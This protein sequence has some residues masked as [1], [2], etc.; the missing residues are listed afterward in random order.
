VLE[1][2]KKY[3]D[4]KQYDAA[5]TNVNYITRVLGARK[6]IGTVVIEGTDACDDEALVEEASDLAATADSTFSNYD[7]SLYT[8]RQPSRARFRF[9]RAARLTCRS[10]PLRSIG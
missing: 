7:S 2:S 5:R 10:E 6:S 1:P 9:D 8:V 4:L 3:F